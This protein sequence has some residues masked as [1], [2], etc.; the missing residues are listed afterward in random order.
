[1]AR[2]ERFDAIV[3]AGGRGSRLGGVDK[4]ALEID[5]RSL[6]TLALDAVAGAQCVVVVRGDDDVQ[7]DGR[8]CRVVE[9]PRWSGPAA[10]VE[11]GLAE[12]DRR[13]D[14]GSGLVAVVAADLPRVAEAL[15]MLWRSPLG[16]RADGVLAIDPGGRDQPLLAVYRASALRDALHTA[17]P[18]A[19]LGIHRVIS[20]LKLARVPLAADLCAD[21][22]TPDD[23]AGFAIAL[24]SGAVYA[25]G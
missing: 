23:A 11:A 21:V 24:P 5:G 13:A 4:P 9:R 20:T 22:D 25:A 17:Q 1:M 12:L 16:A 2:T 10:A 3:L 15:R 14:G 8:V 6:L 7:V 19:G 18:V